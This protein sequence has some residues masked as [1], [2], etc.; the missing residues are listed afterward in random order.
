MRS[1]AFQAFA[2]LTALALR[3]DASP[4]GVSFATLLEAETTILDQAFEYPEGNPKITA[5]ML[6]VPPRATIALHKHPVP[7]FVYILKG[8][9]TV[10]YDGIGPVTYRRGDSFV[11]AFE[12]PHRAWNGGRGRAKLLTVYAGA[13]GTENSVLLPED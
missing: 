5:L 4:P 11:E 1:A 8:S 9:I 13:A 2:V 6:T 3:A 7:L 12:W 10:E